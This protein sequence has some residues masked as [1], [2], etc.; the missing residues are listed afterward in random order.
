MKFRVVGD[1]TSTDRLELAR[2]SSPAV[3]WNNVTFCR[4]SGHEYYGNGKELH[5]T[6]GLA[7][8]NI[9]VESLL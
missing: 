9:S 2:G 3:A 8:M 5:S 7:Q 4:S 6:Q 1:P